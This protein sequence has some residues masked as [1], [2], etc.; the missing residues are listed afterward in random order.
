MIQ[1]EVQT[2]DLDNDFHTISVSNFH[3]DTILDEQ[4]PTDAGR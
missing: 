4:N 2:I 1:M 3:Y